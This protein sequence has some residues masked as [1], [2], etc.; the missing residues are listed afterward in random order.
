M[1]AVDEDVLLKPALQVNT[2][3]EE[4]SKLASTNAITQYKDKLHRSQRLYSPL[5]LLDLD[6]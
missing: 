5:R 2:F 4:I 1:A 3:F 6:Q